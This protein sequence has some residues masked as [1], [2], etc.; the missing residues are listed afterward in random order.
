MAAVNSKSD[1]IPEADKGNSGFGDHLQN[2]SK[3][4]KKYIYAW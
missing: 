1:P 3:Q 4:V 2:K